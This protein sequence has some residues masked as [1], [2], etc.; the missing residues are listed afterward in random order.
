MAQEKQYENNIAYPFRFTEDCDLVT[1]TD[2]D[3]IKSYLKVL[4]SVSRGTVPLTVYFG[5]ALELS[6]FEAMTE[7]DQLSLDSSIR[8]AIQNNLGDKVRIDQEIIFD[9]LASY[10]GYSVLIP[11]TIIANGEATYVK[12]T[13]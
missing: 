1:Q 12:Y 13:Q 8:S 5:T 11:I 6:V 10:D 2:S 3:V 4:I 9:E 7:E